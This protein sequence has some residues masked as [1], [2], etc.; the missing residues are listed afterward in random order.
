MDGQGVVEIMN[1]VHHGS[2]WVMEMVA[3]SMVQAA[4]LKEGLVTLVGLAIG[5]VVALVSKVQAGLPGFQTGLAESEGIV[6]L[7]KLVVLQ[8]DSS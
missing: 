3:W 5:C 1:V 6:C 4:W 2:K 7:A 8:A